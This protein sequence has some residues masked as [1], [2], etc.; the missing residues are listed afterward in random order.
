M[1]ILPA[2]KII[3]I[4]R[5]RLRFSMAGMKVLLFGF[6]IFLSAIA[7]AETPPE[8]ADFANGN[9]VKFSTIDHPKAGAIALT[10]KYPQSWTPKEGE[11]P[12][13]VQKFVRPGGLVSAMLTTRTIPHPKGKP[14]D[15][16]VL[17]V[18]TPE[19]NLKQ[20]P[21]NCIAINAKRTKIDNL[22]C[23]MMEYSMHSENAGMEVS[24]QMVSFTFIYESTVCTFVGSV[25]A[26]TAQKDQLHQKMAELMPVFLLM[27][28][29]IIVEKKW[30]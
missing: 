24:A 30:K 1:A 4:A 7:H 22:P 2:W 29:S 13:I 5:P 8:I 26:P 28:N 25:G 6:L 17:L 15:E 10:L 16:E 27:A 19:I 9:V 11:R 12:H 21:E 14:S 3:G 18:L 23:C 20:L